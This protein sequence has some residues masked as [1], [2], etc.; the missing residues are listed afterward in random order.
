MGIA[1]LFQGRER[2]AGRHWTSAALAITLI[3]AGLLA[4][5]APAAGGPPTHGRVDLASDA[6]LRID[7]SAEDE[8]AGTKVDSAGDVNG[9]GTPDVIV[10]TAFTPVAYVVFGGGSG[11]VDLA[12][13][14]TSG[15]RIE[16]PSS[17]SGLSVSGAGD[18][19]GDGRDD[20]IVGD[21]DSNLAWVV[22]GEVGTRTVDLD[23][24]GSRGFRI[25]G[26][27]GD[28][29]GSR[30][31]DAGDVNGDGLADVVVSAFGAS[32]NDRLFSGS[33]Y[34]VFGKRGT[35]P[36]DLASLGDWGYRIDGAAA[37][38]FSHAVSG[39]GDFNG[40]GRPDVLLGAPRLS[41]PASVY[42]VLGRSAGGAVDL[43]DPGSAVRIDYPAADTAGGRAF[44][45][46]GDVNGDGLADVV[47][48]AT[49][50][51]G[52]GLSGHVVFGRRSTGPVDLA[53][54]GSG[55]F[56]IE[57]GSPSGES[58]PVA[59]V[60]DVNGDGLADVG[61]GLPYADTTRER[62]AGRSFVVFGRSATAP[63]N[64]GHLGKGGFQI[65]GAAAHDVAGSAIAA[66]GDVDGDRR[67]D[68]LVGAPGANNNGRRDSG[69]VYLVRGRKCCRGGA[70]P[71]P[72][73]RSRVRSLLDPPTA[74]ITGGGIGNWAAPAGDMNGD[75][76]DDVVLG[77]YDRQ[78]GSHSAHVV[79]GTA[80]RSGTGLPALGGRGFR[81]DLPA[82]E[83]LQDVDGAG[84]VNGDG[85]DDVVVGAP[86]QYPVRGGS[87]YIVFGRRST[88][89]IDL[90]ALGQGG[91][92]I[93]GGGEDY[94]MPVAGAGDVNGDRRSDV[95]VGT[96]GAGNNGRVSSG[97]A[98][99][100][101]GKESSADVELGSLGPGGFRIDGARMNSHA[102][103]FVAGP[104]DVNGDGRTDVLVRAGRDPDDE[105]GSG[106]TYVVFGKDS[107]A[108]V[109]LAVLGAGGYRIH[110]PRLY[111]D[112]DMSMDAAGDV[113]GDGL[114][115][116][117][118]A[119]PYALTLEREAAGGTYVVYGKS[120][121]APVR[122]AALGSAGVQILGDLHV[123]QVWRVAGAGDF[124]RDGYGDVVLGVPDAY[125]DRQNTGAAYLVYGRRSS[126]TIDLAALGRGGVRYGGSGDESAGSAV[127]GAG[128]F[129]GDRRADVI[130]GAPFAGGPPAYPGAA[131]VVF[132][133]SGR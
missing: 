75:G 20:V 24:L 73:P 65:D 61:L 48:G 6:A 74:T 8:R 100:V 122:L 46:A 50:R 95:I 37:R 17:Y 117:V 114:G 81:I 30:V 72:G 106:T 44:D 109:D 121:T 57:G 3:V 129:D 94:Y 29:L 125:R 34:V 77:A 16:A 85:L 108:P 52:P 93:S 127:A 112:S 99:V 111:D 55:G 39:A 7:G 80:S 58:P 26:G 60:G 90:G 47:L 124:N 22:F 2:R 119:Y 45:G 9:D 76:L 70:A 63:V 96:P 98:Y 56:T 19:N 116:V 83:R 101:F 13:P 67:G 69:S 89:P 92:R 4:T 64:L 12:D 103:S 104:G 133:R 82:G 41:R 68:V 49:E 33:A 23:A 105:F 18:V 123:G 118:I 31:D 91:F 14:G 71:T 53:A 21:Y 88:D 120:S 11:S 66:A 51:S 78:Q 1:E 110:G 42:V 131:Y 86:K 15:F 97:S 38:D 87:A 35:E 40:D 25:E 130:V 5:A 102:G 54:L 79:F 28:A 10:A 43:A 126:A 59:G 132:G 36:V 115:D 107:S 27:L 32:R 84:D 128:D 62:Y 113:N